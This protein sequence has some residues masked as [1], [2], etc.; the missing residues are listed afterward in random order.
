MG[1]NVFAMGLRAERSARLWRRGF[2]TGAM[3]AVAAGLA[4]D[5]RTQEPLRSGTSAQH[6]ARGVTFHEAR[7]LDEASREYARV[8]TM[9]PPRPPSAA[10]LD[11]I[12]R[13]TPRLHTTVDEFFPLKDFAAVLHPT[14]RLIAYHLFWEDD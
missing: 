5:A 3:V 4:I 1:W 11:V 6:H 8:L 10:E 14:E 12:R 7:R 2:Q 9:D 13:F